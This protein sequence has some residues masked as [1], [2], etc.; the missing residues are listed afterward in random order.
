MLAY[1]YNRKKLFIY[2]F[3]LKKN[4]LEYK[5]EIYDVAKD[6]IT[7]EMAIVKIDFDEKDDD[8]DDDE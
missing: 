3:L 7:I 8:E 2:F 5:K 1:I 4:L 6:S